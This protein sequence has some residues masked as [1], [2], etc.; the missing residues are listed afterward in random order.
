VPDF[1]GQGYADYVEELRANSKDPFDAPELKFNPEL[2]RS[3]LKKAGYNIV[4]KNGGFVAEGVPP[5]ELLYN[6]SEGH[7]AVAVTI[8]DM[9]K[10][11]L[12][13]EVQ[14]RNEEWGVMLKNVRDKNFQ[15]VRFGWIAD[16]DHPQTFL[17]TFMAKSP[18]NRTGW[19]N[20]K[21][22]ALVQ[23]ARSTADVK[24]SMR[25]YREAEGILAEEVPKIPL[26]FYTKSTLIKP[27]VKGFHF[28]RRNEQLTQWM[29]LDPNWKNNSSDEPAFQV[30]A[31]AAPAAY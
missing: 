2:A 30:P 3:L 13:I 31:F 10:K 29:W 20:A 6:T 21:Y 4:E 7:R 15:V 19:S 8:Q 26:Y 27:Y 12:G 25:L 16:F 23:R 9:W 5:I 28:N 11:N 24:E 18:N 17:D 1:M 22:D 14:L